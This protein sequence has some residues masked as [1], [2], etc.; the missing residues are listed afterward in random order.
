MSE[1]NSC[2]DIPYQGRSL[3]TALYTKIESD[4]RGMDRR[5]KHYPE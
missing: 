2:D 5:Q 1:G 3:D 4:K